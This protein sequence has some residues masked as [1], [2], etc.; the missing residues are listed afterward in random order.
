MVSRRNG[1]ETAEEYLRIIVQEGFGPAF[2]EQG[3]RLPA[4][5]D[6]DFDSPPTEAARDRWGSITKGLPRPTACRR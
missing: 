6:I 3:Y 1:P 5:I 2:A 4:K